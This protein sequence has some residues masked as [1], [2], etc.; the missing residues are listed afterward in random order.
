MEFLCNAKKL[1]VSFQNFA[2]NPKQS[3]KRARFIVDKQKTGHSN[4][5]HFSVLFSA[6]GAR[7]VPLDNLKMEKT[8]VME[9]IIIPHTQQVSFSCRI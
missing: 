4:Q 8:E 6:S 3:N 2:F 9:Q 7:V 1:L 5:E